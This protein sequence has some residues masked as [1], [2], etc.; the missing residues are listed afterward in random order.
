MLA[1]SLEY[2]PVEGA[3]W[4]SKQRP[5]PLNLLNAQSAPSQS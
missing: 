2:M 5:I 1:K 4:T 3:P